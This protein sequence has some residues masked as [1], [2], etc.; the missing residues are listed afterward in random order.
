M[1][2]TTA[3]W[4]I[5]IMIFVYMTAG[6]AS[7]AQQRL[8]KELFLSRDYDAL[9]RPVEH[10]NETVNVTFALI[11]NILVFVS[12]QDQ[13]MK[14]NGY[15]DLSWKDLRLTWNPEEYDGISILRLPPDKLWQPDIAL[16]NTVDKQF[17]PNYK[18]NALI[19]SDGSVQW[20]PPFIFK[21]GCD[22]NPYFFPFDRQ[23]CNMV[24]RSLTYSSA[25]VDLITDKYM[26]LKD[27][28]GQPSGS[29]NIT[30]VPLFKWY[31]THYRK[32]GAVPYV[33]VQLDMMVA[34]KSQFYVLTFL[35]PCVCIAFLTVFVFYLPIASGEK[36]CLAISILFS[37]VIFLLILIDILP[38]SDSLPLMTKFLVFCFVCNLISAFLTTITVNFSFRSVKTHIMVRWIRM[39]LMEKIPQLLR[40]VQPEKGKKKKLFATVQVPSPASSSKK[41]SLKAKPTKDADKRLSVRFSNPKPDIKERYMNGNFADDLWVPTPPKRAPPYGS[42]AFHN[43]GFVSSSESNKELIWR[44][45]QHLGE[46]LQ[47]FPGYSTALD[48]VAYIAQNMEEQDEEGDVS[49]DWKFVALAADRF[50]LWI[51]LIGNLMG[52]LSILLNS[53]YLFERMPDPAQNPT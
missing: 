53:P 34:R 12:D 42:I 28:E 41:S 15:L 24:F 39:I 21:S 48:N 44:E 50:L 22:T 33:S 35:L 32:Y 49:D 47:Q 4:T 43:P 51:F 6:L 30:E 29:W 27:Y 37:I 10:E 11:L 17:L 3:K 9:S 23:L 14:T 46:Y 36:L 5:V 20:V 40:I 2:F 31:R 8:I 25:E 38:P 1:W 16:T 7:D 52:T 18:S 26:T 13:V 19:S 45:L